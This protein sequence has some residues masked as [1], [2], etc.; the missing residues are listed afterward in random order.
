MRGWCLNS[1]KWHFFNKLGG[2]KLLCA[3]KRNAYLVV[4]I[5]G[6]FQIIEGPTMV[7]GY[8]A[9]FFARF[10]KIG[11]VG[12]WKIQIFSRINLL[13][14]FE[15]RKHKLNENID[16]LKS[17]LGHFCFEFMK[18]KL[19]L[20]LRLWLAQL[21][22]LFGWSC[23]WHRNSVLCTFFEEVISILQLPAWCSTQKAAVCFTFP[24]RTFDV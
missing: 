5:I 24:R 17:T 8:R 23:I 4:S 9:C 16:I 2:L 6:K 10:Y 13:L 11:A 7:C 15:N 12:C 14:P 21:E 1:N 22:L 18:K 19:I 3:T 20:L